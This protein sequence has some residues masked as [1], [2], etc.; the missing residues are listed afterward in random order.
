MAVPRTAPSRPRPPAVAAVMVRRVVPLAP[1]AVSV[2][3][4]L[5]VSLRISP[6]VMASTPRATSSPTA[7]APVKDL[8][9]RYLSGLGLDSRPGGRGQL[10]GAV[11]LRRG[12]VG[13]AA[14]MIQ[15][16]VT[17][18]SPRARIARRVMTVFGVDVPEGR[19]GNRLDGLTAMQL[20]AGQGSA[21]PRPGGLLGGDEELH[22]WPGG[23]SRA[24]GQHVGGRADPA[25]ADPERAQQGRGGHVQRAGVV[26]GLRARLVER[27]LEGAWIPRHMRSGPGGRVQGEDAPGSPARWRP[28]RPA[29]APGSGSAGGG[30]L[31]PWYRL[32]RGRRWLRAGRG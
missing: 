6:T 25:G 12:Q 9:Q 10:P 23:Q 3:R 14:R 27:R 30:S 18:R 1:A 20:P 2:R 5:L 16:E 11:D 31:R 29:P 32:G 15:P 21:D 8:P 19:A 22:L 24:H 7:V 26:V 28:G 4:S 17:S 13:R